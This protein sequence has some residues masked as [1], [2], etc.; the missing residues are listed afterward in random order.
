M[1]GLTHWKPQFVRS[2]IIGLG[3]YDIAVEAD[4]IDHIRD[5]QKKA[6]QDHSTVLTGVDRDMRINAGDIGAAGPVRKRTADSLHNLFN[7]LVNRELVGEAVP[8]NGTGKTVLLKQGPSIDGINEE[9][10]FARPAGVAHTLDI[11]FTGDRQ[12]VG[13]R[14]IANGQCNLA[15]AL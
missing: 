15:A 7:K 6:A 11:V 12:Q 8:F 13:T 5:E 1:T 4:E 2:C 10:V 9:Q 14:P 3:I